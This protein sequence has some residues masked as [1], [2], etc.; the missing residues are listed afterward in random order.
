MRAFVFTDK[1]LERQAG[2]FVWLEWDTEKS[3][4]AWLRKKFP[5]EALPTYFIVDPADE[6]VALRW[7]GGATAAQ[8]QKILDD[9]RASVTRADAA[10]ARGGKRAAASLGGSY[11]AAA[12]AFAQGDALYAAADYAAAVA[13]FQMALA[14]APP[15]WPRY[16]RAVESLLYALSQT[17]AHGPGA[18]LALASFPRLRHT[19]SAANVVV[20]GLDCAIQLPADSTSRAGMISDLEGAAR[21]VVADSS[22]PIAADDRSAVYIGLLDARQDA[23]DEEGAKEVAGEW[24]AFLEGEARRATTP[25]QRAVFDSHRLSAYLQ[26]GQPERA[27]PMLEASERDLPTDYNPP[28]R[29]AVAYKAMKRWDQALAASDRALPKAYG[30]RKLGILQTRADIYL[31]LAD[32]TAA[33]RTLGDAVGM[34]ES[35]PTGQRSENAIASLK[36]KLSAL[37]PAAATP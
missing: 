29:L 5:V 3:R 22:L 35:L 14:E 20:M 31:G 2:R 28:A 32:T 15:D 17:A 16:S 8:L 24:A 7:V 26:L 25:E 36:K 12:A 11:A 19:A 1:A 34:A 23:K 21:E 10:L 13:P 37:Q 33:R 27:V 4:N 30:P 18:R 6:R 9:G